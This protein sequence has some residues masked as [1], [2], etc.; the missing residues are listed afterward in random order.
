[1]GR[2]G[3]AG[4]RIAGAAQ[5]HDALRIGRV[6]LTTTVLADRQLARPGCDLRRYRE[7]LVEL[8]IFGVLAGSEIA[9]LAGMFL[10]VPAIAAVRII[11]RRL[12]APEIPPGNA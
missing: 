10:S 12:Q 5:D 11:W 7:D 6:L 3:S 4:S 8:V 2:A 9:G 1:M